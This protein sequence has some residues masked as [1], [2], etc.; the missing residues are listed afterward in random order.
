[1]LQ[2]GFAARTVPYTSFDTARA[3]DTTV[4][5]G[6][7]EDSSKA[8]EIIEPSIFELDQHLQVWR[9]KV[10]SRVDLI[11][12]ATKKRQEKR[13]KTVFATFAR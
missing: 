9:K 7:E 11:S 6:L 10:V 4:I 3:I 12:T 5:M 13:E 1:M 8:H 2:K